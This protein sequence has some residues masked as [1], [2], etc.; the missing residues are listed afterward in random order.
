MLKF[1][2]NQRFDQP[3]LEGPGR[4]ESTLTKGSGG[5]GEGPNPKSGKPGR[6][7]KFPALP[8]ES[9]EFW[10]TDYSASMA[11]LGSSAAGRYHAQG[12]SVM[13]EDGGDADILP[14]RGG[15]V[16][17]GRDAALI[18]MWALRG[19]G[20]VGS[21]ARPAAGRPCP[22]A[23]SLLWA[24]SL[25]SCTKVLRHFLKYREKISADLSLRPCLFPF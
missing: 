3:N 4:N 25:S 10:F 19:P 5:S 2:Q 21:A 15:P 6:K 9:G 14:R 20:T 11:P 16:R 18:M 7:S 24:G 22:P 17:S 8:R 1:P 12:T 23:R 13:E